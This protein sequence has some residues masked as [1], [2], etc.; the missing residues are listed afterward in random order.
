MNRAAEHDKD[1]SRGNFPSPQG[2]ANGKRR[3]LVITKVDRIFKRIQGRR[4][5]S[6]QKQ[7][8]LKYLYF[9][10]CLEQLLPFFHPLNMPNI[11][12]N[13]PVTLLWG[14]LAPDSVIDISDIETTVPTHPTQ[15]RG[16]LDA[17]SISVIMSMC[18]TWG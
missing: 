12:G 15:I 7:R 8:P 17:Y 2:M 14:E 11:T 18:T 4:I 6:Y 10:E 16:V 13:Q 1:T 3:P 9:P 5:R